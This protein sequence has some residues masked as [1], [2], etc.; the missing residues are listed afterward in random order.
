MKPVPW[1][2]LGWF[3]VALVALMMAIRA[4]RTPMPF[5]VQPPPHSTVLPLPTL[6]SQPAQAASGV[7]PVI[8]PQTLPAGARPS[9]AAGHRLLKCVVNGQVTYTNNPQ[10][11]PVGAASSVTVYPTQGYLPTKPPS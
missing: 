3:T 5:V 8:T 1:A 11:C 7:H 4:F 10:E 6:Q 2:A 9:I